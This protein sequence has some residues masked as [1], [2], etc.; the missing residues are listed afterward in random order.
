[1]A[2][3]QFEK[4]FAA[5]APMFSRKRPS[6]RSAPLRKVVDRA[7]SEDVSRDDDP[8]PVP[9]WKLECGH[10]VSPPVDIHGERFPARMRCGQC[11][12]EAA[13]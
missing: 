3:R 10:L 11:Q 12:A 1:M 4:F 5:T 13:A 8:M 9:R 2:S 6:L 7:E